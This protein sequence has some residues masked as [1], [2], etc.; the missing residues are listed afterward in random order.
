MVGMGDK[1]MFSLPIMGPA[2]GFD[3]DFY[4]YCWIDNCQETGHDPLG[5]CPL[6]EK[7][8]KRDEFN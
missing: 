7:Q 8:M 2:Q 5:L 1:T 3:D 6:H 4:P